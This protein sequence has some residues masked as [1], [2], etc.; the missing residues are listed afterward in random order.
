MRQECRACRHRAEF[1]RTVRLLLPPVVMPGPVVL[2]HVRTGDV[3]CLVDGDVPLSGMPTCGAQR[4]NPKKIAWREDRG[5]SPSLSSTSL[6][7]MHGDLGF[8][9]GP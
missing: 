6:I 2:L 7:E 5:T 8:G 9:V 3:I 1:G 4:G